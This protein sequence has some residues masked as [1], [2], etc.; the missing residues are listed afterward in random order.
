MKKNFLLFAF[1]CMLSFVAS[2]QSVIINESAGWLESAFLKWQ[3]VEGGDLKFTFDNLVDDPSYAVNT[4]MK[5][6][7]TISGTPTANVSFS[8]TTSGSAGT[9]ITLTGSITIDD[10]TVPVGA[11]K[12]LGAC[13][14]G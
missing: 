4:A 13:S 3:P 10:G 7:L 6:T 11:S 8:V 5:S 14:T 2:A 12:G 9:P 1:A